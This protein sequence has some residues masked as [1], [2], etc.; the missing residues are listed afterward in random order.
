[1]KT[2]KNWKARCS[3]A[4]MTIVG[5]DEAGDTLTVT[6]VEQIEAREDGVFAML[7][8]ESEYRLGTP[9]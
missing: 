7:N 3:G 2:I 1:M 6:V 5:L 8:D 4:T 9:K